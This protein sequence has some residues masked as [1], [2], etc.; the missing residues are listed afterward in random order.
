MNRDMDYLSA[1]ELKEFAQNAQFQSSMDGGICMLFTE[2]KQEKDRFL[3]RIT[4]P[5]GVLDNL[6]IVAVGDNLVLY[7]LRE[8]DKL[9]NKLVASPN[10]MTTFELPSVIDKNRID[11][12][13]SDSAVFVTLPVKKELENKDCLNGVKITRKSRSSVSD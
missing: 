9:P 7:V 3:L 4:A 6:K 8:N 1:M 11:V 13:S 5:E 10:N 2:F 12:Y